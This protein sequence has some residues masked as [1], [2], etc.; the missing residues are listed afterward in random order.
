MQNAAA[1]AAGVTAAS[2]AGAFVHR[3]MSTMTTTHSFILDGV[4][5]ANLG[6]KPLGY[7]KV[8]HIDDANNVGSASV[9]AG[10]HSLRVTARR[11][12]QTLPPNTV[13]AAPVAEFHEDDLEA[14]GS[15]LAFYWENPWEIKASAIR[16]VRMLASRIRAT[17]RQL[18]SYITAVEQ[19]ADDVAPSEPHRWELISVSVDNTPVMGDITSHPFFASVGMASNNGQKSEYSKTRAMYVMGGL[20]SVAVGLGARR[21]YSN[22]RMWPPYVFAR[23][24]VQ[25]HPS[26]KAFYAQN[27][28]VEVVTRTGIFRPALIEGEITITGSASKNSATVPTESVVKFT[29]SKAKDGQWMVSQALMTPTG[30]KPIDLL[31][32]S[33]L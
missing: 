1:V 25:S 2:L 32:V 31:V 12:V 8:V 10:G 20:V 16:G 18:A 5:A 19:D 6:D 7:W 17:K 33:K 4:R 22:Y 26:V 29:A 24:F 9:S 30:C 15:G 13:T 21:V 14:E 28:G 27:E 23:N 3:Q 11:I